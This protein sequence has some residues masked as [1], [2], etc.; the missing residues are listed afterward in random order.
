MDQ[1]WGLT[2]NIPHPS[3][4]LK[5]TPLQCLPGR[6]PQLLDTD[7]YLSPIFSPFQNGGV[8]GSYPVSPLSLLLGKGAGTNFLHMSPDPERNAD[9]GLT[10]VRTW[11]L[12]L[13][14]V[15]G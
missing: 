3:G 2:S 15:I 10:T 1:D 7:C 5:A 11:T 13:I 4:R 12:S 6:I 8:Y 9:L 14:F